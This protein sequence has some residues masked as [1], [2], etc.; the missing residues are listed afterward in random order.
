MIT[1]PSI[2]RTLLPLSWLYGLGVKVRNLLFTWEVYKEESFPIPVIC[3]GNLTVGGTGK[4]PHTEY[5]IRLLRH[6][7]TAILSRGY[8]RETKGFVLASPTTTAKQIGDEPYQ[9]YQ[10]FPFT[11]VAVQEKRTEG[12]KRL[13]E[14]HHPQVILLDDAYQHRYVKAGLN[15]LLTDYNRLM[16]RDHLLPA[17]RLREPLSGKDRAHVIIITKCPV[18][19]A[20]E[21]QELRQEIKPGSNQHLFFSQI[22]YGEPQAI[23]QAKPF[24]WRDIS[25]HTPILLLAGIANPA[26]LLKQIQQYS[27]QVKLMEFRDHHT[28]TSQELENIQETLKGMGPQALLF[29][30]E[31]DAARLKDMP[32]SQELQSRMYQIPIQVQ[33]TSDQ[34][35]D[36]DKLIINFVEHFNPVCKEQK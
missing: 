25:S 34:Q 36:F 12:I 21:L 5:L 3:L 20:N 22:Y 33:I 6:Y 26:P 35:E 27:R 28:F 8:G 13:M 18:L 23:F 16:T 15:I 7:D 24:T 1:I 10:K 2:H 29:T 19:T 11:T 14:E 31:K 17:G 30:T 32:L 4:T 9:I